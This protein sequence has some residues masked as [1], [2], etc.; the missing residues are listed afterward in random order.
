MQGVAAE[1]SAIGCTFKGQIGMVI[2]AFAGKTLSK[3]VGLALCPKVN[4][5]QALGFARSLEKHPCEGFSCPPLLH[6]GC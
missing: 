3:Q 5:F 1:A 6:L 4:V 2:A